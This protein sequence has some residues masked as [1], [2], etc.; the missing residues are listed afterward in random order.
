MQNLKGPHF[1]HYTPA[2]QE[3]PVHSQSSLPSHLKNKQ[4]LSLFI[5]WK[6]PH[7]LHVFS[8]MLGHKERGDVPPM[9]V[10]G[11]TLLLPSKGPQGAMGW[12]CQSTHPT[13]A[14][15]GAKWDTEHNVRV[16]AL[17][18]LSKQPCCQHSSPKVFQLQIGR[19]WWEEKKSTSSKLLVQKLVQNCWLLLLQQSSFV[20]SFCQY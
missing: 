3:F 6:L 10:H 12:H 1:S 4:L 13:A 7:L 17:R 18:S 19:H 11:S 20:F 8:T 2:H 14:T 16:T 15:L 5:C 9:A